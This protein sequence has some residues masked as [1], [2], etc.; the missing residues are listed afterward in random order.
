LLDCDAIIK[1]PDW[2]ESKGAKVECDLANALKMPLFNYTS[3]GLKYLILHEWN[4]LQSTE[5]KAKK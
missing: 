5:P 1:L 2:Y 4:N 3:T